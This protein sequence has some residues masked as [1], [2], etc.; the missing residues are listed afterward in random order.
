MRSSHHCRRPTRRHAHTANSATTSDGLRSVD[1]DESDRLAKVRILQNGEAAAVTYLTNG[2]GQRVFKSEPKADQYLPDEEELGV[3]FIAWLKSKFRWMFESAQASASVGTSFAYGE[4]DIPPWA[5]LSEYDNGSASGT[6]RTEYI[7]LPLKDGTAVPIGMWRNNRMYT[8]HPDHLGTPR[9]VKDD[10]NTPVWQ[11][12][13]SAFGNNRPVG[14]LSTTTTTGYAITPGTTPLKAT[15]PAT[16]LNLRFP[17]QYADSETGEFYNYFP[18]YD[19]RTGRYTQADPIGIEGGW[20]RFGYV[21]GNPL[22]Y[23]DPEGLQNA[24]ALGGL[25]VG[26]GAAAG[27]GAGAAAVSAAVAGTVVAGAGLV[28]YGVGSLIYPLV[29]NPSP[30]LLIHVLQLWPDRGDGPARRPAT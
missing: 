26:A 12:P 15:Q 8:I 6:G 9:L 17:G 20:N 29:E 18:Q 3:D 5:L 21:G 19:A 2:L 13:Y 7:W 10:T 1:D 11:L 30:M 22:S 28:G 27:A 14:V 24:A 4:G 16:R 23:A 25:G